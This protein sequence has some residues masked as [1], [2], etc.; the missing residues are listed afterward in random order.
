MLNISSWPVVAVVDDEPVVAA[1]PVACV[2]T[3]A[4]LR[5]HF[6]QEPKQ[7]LLVVAVLERPLQ[8]LCVV[9]MARHRLSGR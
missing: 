4:T 8:V 1:V 2:P 5:S 3:L 6:Q 9:Q 7:L